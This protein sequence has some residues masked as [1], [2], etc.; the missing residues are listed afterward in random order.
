MMQRRPGITIGMPPKYEGLQKALAYL[1]D[2]P[3]AKYSLA[4]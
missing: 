2:P 1:A 3:F 4:R